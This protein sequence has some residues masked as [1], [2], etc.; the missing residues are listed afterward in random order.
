MTVMSFTKEELIATE[1]FLRVLKNTGCF[2]AG[3][4]DSDPTTLPKWID[5]VK[6]K[7]A[8]QVSNVSSTS[9]MPSH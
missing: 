2:R 8:K 5:Y 9:W 7:R 4:N 1:E 6:L 3:D